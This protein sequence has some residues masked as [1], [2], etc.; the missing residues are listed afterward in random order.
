M[1]QFL[2]LLINGVSLGAVYA[3]IALGFVIIFKASEVVSFMHGSLILL[4]HGL[5]Q[6]QSVLQVGLATVRPDG[7]DLKWVGDGKGDEHLPDWGT[8]PC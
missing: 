1:N 5:H 2:S 6:G 8:A 3:L 7:T 4:V